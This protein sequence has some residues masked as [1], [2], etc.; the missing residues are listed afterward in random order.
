M[1]S[2]SQVSFGYSMNLPTSLP[3][4]S[5][6]TVGMFLTLYFTVIPAK[7]FLVR[8]NEIDS[9]GM[10]TSSKTR[11]TPG[12]VVQQSGHHVPWKRM[13]FNLSYFFK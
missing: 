3:S 4:F 7:S 6:M 12:I 1:K 8:S 9:N 11:K 13:A 2:S 10:F 5:K